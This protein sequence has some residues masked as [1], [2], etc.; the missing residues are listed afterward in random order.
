MRGKQGRLLGGSHQATQCMETTLRRRNKSRANAER[1]SSGAPRVGCPS[2][3]A[4]TWWYMSEMK[5]AASAESSTHR[6]AWC[7]CARAC[8]F[9]G[10]LLRAPLL[11]FTL[12]ERDGP[13]QCNL[14]PQR[15]L[16]SRRDPSGSTQTRGK[17]EGKIWPLCRPYR[18]CG[19]PGQLKC[20][21]SHRSAPPAATART[22]GGNG[23]RRWI[24][25]GPPSHRPAVT[26]PH[27]HQL[28]RTSVPVSPVP[29]PSTKTPPQ[30]RGRRAASSCPGSRSRAPPS[31][32]APPARPWPPAAQRAAKVGGHLGCSADTDERRHGVGSGSRG[33]D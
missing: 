26:P 15:G 31:A 11:L 18:C 22:R 3:R 30:R 5:A 12:D 13:I 7:V 25:C 21:H 4:C 33:S 9:D 32:S 1:C 2:T 16:H 6:S 27:S 29:N 10:C 28:V 20:I 23:R 19:F 14:K 17:F 24:R 8:V